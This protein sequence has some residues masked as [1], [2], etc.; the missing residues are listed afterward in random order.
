[1]VLVTGGSGLV[2]TELI[3][4]L[5]KSGK[6]VRAIENTTPIKKG[7]ASQIE[8]IKADILDVVALEDAMDGI[9]EVYHCAGLVSYDP[10]MKTQLFKI[11]TEGTANIVNAALNENVSKFLFVSSVAA[12]KKDENQKL[13]NEN[14]YFKDI[15]FESTYAKTKYLAEL[16]VWR[17][18]AEGLNAVIINPSIILGYSPFDGGS[19][20]IFKSVFN[21]FPWFTP[22]SAGFVDVRDVAK[23]AILLMDSNVSGERFIVSASNKKFKEIFSEIAATFGKKAPYKKASPLMASLVWRIEK[24]KSNFNNSKPLVTKETA[25]AAFNHSL[26]NNEKL[27]KYFPEFLYHNIDD[28]IKYYCRF[29]NEAFN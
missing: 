1:M 29:Y 14:L 4:Q 19:S 12:L 23:A 27:L 13:I 21:E 18:I 20:E 7:F 3:L 16:E 11:N 15:K 9:T 24:L 28:S 6:S 8:I 10:K 22:G 5:L 26:Y 2:G 17:G 25:K